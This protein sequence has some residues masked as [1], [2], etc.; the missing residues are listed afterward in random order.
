MSA[1]VAVWE[2]ARR[3]VVERSRS[4]VLQVSLVVLL[5]VAVG[6][7]VAAARLTGGTPTDKIGLVGPRSVALKRAIQLEAKAAGRHVQLYELSTQAT[8]ARDVRNGT[9][10][11]ALVD[12]SRMLVKSSRSLAAVRE[13]R[14]AIGVQAVFDRLR[15]SGLSQAQALSALSPPAVQVVALEVNTRNTAGNRALVAIGVI[16]LFALLMF[17][18]Q[19][20]AQGVTEEKSS[21]VV[22]LLLTTVS[23]RRLLMGKVLG[24]G[25]LGLALVLLP[26]AAALGAGS[27]AGGAGLPSATPKAIALVALWFVLGYFLFSVAYAAVGAMVSR[28]ED[29]TT[30]QVPIYIVA[31]AGFLVA[32]IAANTNPDGT[33]AQVAGFVPPFSAMVVP[34]RMVVGRMGWIALTAAV[35]LDVIATA[36]LIVLA[37]GIYERS[38]LHTGARVKFR[39][40]LTARSQQPKPADARPKGTRIMKPENAQQSEPDSAKPRLTPRIEL[41]LRMVGVALVLAG[42]L[43]GFGKPVAIVFVAVGLVL[44]ILDQSLK[45]WPR[46]PAH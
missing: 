38:I 31:M 5:I 2:V 16:S 39:R 37:A 18:G 30:A 17:F 42:A 6:G 24:I 14:N 20:V 12:G 34:V 46:R 41:A 26:G 1:R 13:V 11:V 33:V 8:A 9:F 27:L 19:A 25:A 35:A 22:E 29:L 28:Q 23:P 15:A 3:E 32:D 43:I 10:G 40:V 7:A 21:R 4:R 36:G 45:Y 44:I